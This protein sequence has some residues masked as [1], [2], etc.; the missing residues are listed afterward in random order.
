MKIDSEKFKELKVIIYDLIYFL[1]DEL[2]QSV[3]E[4]N[5]IKVGMSIVEIHKS[6]RDIDKLIFQIDA[7]SEKGKE[8]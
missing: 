5:S 1:L 2:I 6:I 3:N 8:K 7:S 4:N